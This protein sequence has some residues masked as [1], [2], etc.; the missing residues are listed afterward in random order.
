MTGLSALATNLAMDI[1][2]TFWRD[3]FVI[4]RGLFSVGEVTVFREEALKVDDLR[5][6][7]LSIPRLRTVLLDDRLL[8]AVRSLVGQQVVYFGDSSVSVGEAAAGFH[9][10]NPDK[11][12]PAA[13]DWTG[14][15]P[16]IRFG[17]YTQS[18]KGRP[19]GLDLRRGSHEHCST[20][21]GEHVYADTE[22]GDVVIWNLRTSHSGCGMTVKGRPVDPESIAGK[23]LRRLPALR[24]RP[25]VRR[26]ALFGSFGAPGAHLERYIAYLKTRRYAV[27]QF[28][29]SRHD[30]EALALARAKGV[31]VRDMRAEVQER[32]AAQI[33]A[34]HV[35]LPY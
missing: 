15:Y 13:P 22:P 8:S 31:L 28:I 7:L 25:Q 34:T 16:L 12:D 30:A 21:M 17:I 23:I 35:P 10:D 2:P 24:D 14:R 27:D 33:H 3:G 1:S 11:F 5:L 4:V 9:K 18:H 6:D 20:R 19:D 32:P 26:V 29:A